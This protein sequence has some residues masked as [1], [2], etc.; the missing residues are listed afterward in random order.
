MRHLDPPLR[1]LG[2][3]LRHLGPPLRHLG[4]PLRHLGL[5]LRHLRRLRHLRFILRRLRSHALPVCTLCVDTETSHAFSGLRRP[6]ASTL[7]RFTP[8]P[9]PSSGSYRAAA[10]FKGLRQN[11]ICYLTYASPPRS[12]PAPLR[13]LRFILRRAHMHSL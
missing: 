12:S 2:P 7:Q 6:F 5:P 10:V 8:P 1:H 11:L 9:R 4:P 3:P 13:R